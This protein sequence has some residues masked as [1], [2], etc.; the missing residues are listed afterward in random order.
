MTCILVGKWSVLEELAVS[1]CRE[2]ITFIMMEAAGSKVTWLSVDFSNGADFI[3][4]G[5]NRFGGRKFVLKE[6]QDVGQFHNNN[7]VYCNA[8]RSETLRIDFK[9]FMTM[10]SWSLRE[11]RPLRLP[12]S[13]P[14]PTYQRCL[15]IHGIH[16]RNSEQII[17]SIFY[18]LT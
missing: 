1:T 3:P 16:T 10:H 15:H 12:D 2:E 13:T 17:L 7:Q 4:K 8:S 18:I 11:T 5:G 14:P 9:W 6:T